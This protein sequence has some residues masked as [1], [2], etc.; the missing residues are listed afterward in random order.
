VLNRKDIVVPVEAVVGATDSQVQVRLTNDELDQLPEF[1]EEQ[2]RP[3]ENGDALSR[4]YGGGP[5]YVR[6]P[7]GDVPPGLQAAESGQVSASSGGRQIRSGQ[8]VIC[9]DG[10]AG[11]V[12]LVLLDAASHRVTHFVVRRGRLSRRDTVVAIEWVSEITKD[13]LY[14]DLKRDDLDSLPEYRPDEDIAADVL[15]QLWYRS[16]LAPD[17]LQLVSVRVHDGIV[18]LRGHTRTEPARYAIESEARKVRGVL[19]VVNNIEALEA[20]ARQSLSQGADL[21]RSARTAS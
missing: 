17:E 12:R 5:V 10:E 7:G 8:R 18:E 20:L 11:T 15:D 1:R 19:G 21:D 3:S 13:A 2:F 9:L 6:R 16:G 14:L 4:R